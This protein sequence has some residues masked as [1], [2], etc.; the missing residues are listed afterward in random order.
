M[1][2]CR[3]TFRNCENSTSSRPGM[4]FFHF[5]IRDWDRLE[6]WAANAG[7]LDFKDLPVSKLKNKV[8]C[9]EHFENR[10]FMNYL[11]EGLVKTAIPTLDIL[12]DGR[13]WHI[14]SNAVTEREEWVVPEMTS[15]DGDVDSAP[16]ESQTTRMEVS[17]AKRMLCYNF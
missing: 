13:L 12:D 2:G 8:I 11:K 15:T 4:H 10:M 6:V 7:K 3:C 1:G 5:P 9:Q 16:T 17:W 14:E